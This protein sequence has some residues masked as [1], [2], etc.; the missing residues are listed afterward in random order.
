[1]LKEQLTQIF[2]SVNAL[3][4]TK[5]LTDKFEEK[6]RW[7]GQALQDLLDEK[8]SLDK[9]LYECS[10]NSEQLLV[11]LRDYKKIHTDMVQVKDASI[12]FQKEMN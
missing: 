4:S 2:N 10:V 11:N 5:L 6:Q 12:V 7:A 3:S 1:M 8:V 9:K